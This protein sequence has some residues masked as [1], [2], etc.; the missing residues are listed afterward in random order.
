MLV[1][2][3]RPI[4]DADNIAAAATQTASNG[5]VATHNNRSVLLLTADSADR[6][7]DGTTPIQAGAKSGQSLTIIF[8]SNPSSKYVIIQ[9]GGNCSLNGRWFVGSVGIGNLSWLQVIWNGSNWLEVGRGEGSVNSTGLVATAFGRGSTA[10]GSYAQA[11]GS[12]TTASGDVGSH[13]EGASTVASG[14][15]SHAEGSGTT[16]SGSASHA[17]GVSST[18]DGVYSHAQGVR[19]KASLYAEHAQS[20]GRFAADGDAQFSRVLLRGSTADATLTELF[21]DGIDDRLTI[22]DEYTYACKVTVVSR[23]D[24]GTDH[25]MGVFHVLIERT[26]G[27]VAL[28]GAVSTLY[29][30]NA[31]GLGGVT[32]SADDTNK[33]LKVSVQG[34]AGH[35]IRWLATVEMVRVNYAD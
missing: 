13:S 17:E 12:L 11:E 18:A 14:N 5:F 24:T 10:S 3:D 26:G 8:N 7:S 6:Q 32:I 4:I 16:A 9:D 21:I 20:A 2:I 33:S 31:G 23:Q 15:S 29:E 30:N 19:A 22:L 28:L 1:P 34:A 35:N 27:T 25:Y